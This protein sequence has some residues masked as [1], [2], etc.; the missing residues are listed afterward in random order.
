MEEQYVKLTDVR[1]ALK[2][3]DN[4]EEILN[5][6]P[7]YELSNE[8][9]QKENGAELDAI[10]EVIEYLNYSLGTNYKATTAKNKSL[11]RA[12]MREGYAVEDFKTVIDKKVRT[13][14][15]DER[16]QKFLRPETL[17]GTKFESYLNEQDTYKL[18]GNRPTNKQEST[19]DR[20]KRLAEEGAFE[21]D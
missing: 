9:L 16:M 6:L 20:I 21:N 11:I 12:R 17:F 19:Y 7:K 18:S 1:K 10:K 3:I 2:G 4:K 8:N 14:L 13:W 5:A 15:R